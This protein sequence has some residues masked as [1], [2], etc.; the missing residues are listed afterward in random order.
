MSSESSSLLTYA[1][2][3]INFPLS[4]ALASFHTLYFVAFIL[5]ELGVFFL[6]LFFLSHKLFALYM[7]STL[8]FFFNFY[9]FMIVTE[10]E[11]EREAET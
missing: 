10:R 2:S 9:L 3:A 1:F 7:I 6:R 8:L 11:R 4:I 5:I